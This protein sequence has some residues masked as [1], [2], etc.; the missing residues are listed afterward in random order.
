MQGAIAENAG[1]AGGPAGVR[2]AVT[3]NPAVP[4]MYRLVLSLTGKLN[5]L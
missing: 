1:F 3:N 4:A 2:N 5:R